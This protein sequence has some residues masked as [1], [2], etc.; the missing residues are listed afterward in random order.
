MASRL[1]SLSIVHGDIRRLEMNDGTFGWNTEVHG[2]IRRLE[3]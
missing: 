1:M 3:M 2:D